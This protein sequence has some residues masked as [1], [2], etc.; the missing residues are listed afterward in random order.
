MKTEINEIE[1]N[2]EKYVKKGLEDKQAFDANGLEYVI[3]RARSAG[4]FAGYLEKKEGDEVTLR[5]VRRL[6]YWD[7][8]ASCSELAQKGVSKPQNCK[9]PSANTKI[10]IKEWIEILPA[11]E[12]AKK[13]IEGVK[14]WQA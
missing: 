11:T 6:W 14:A 2:G 4:V 13:S 1:I 8:A 3:V 9:F 12:Q 7:G 5:N 10:L